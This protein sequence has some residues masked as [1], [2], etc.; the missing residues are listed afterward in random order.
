MVKYL[1]DRGGNI[2]GELLMG[3][4]FKCIERYSRQIIVE[5]IKDE[6]RKKIDLII[7]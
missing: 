3:D 5:Y 1:V 4:Y 7:S 2:N 6:R